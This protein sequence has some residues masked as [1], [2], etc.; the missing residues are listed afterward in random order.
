MKDA[1]ADRLGAARLLWRPGQGDCGCGPFGNP[2]TEF[3]LSEVE[4]LRGTL[5]ASMELIGLPPKGE[6]RK[7][8]EKHHGMWHRWEG[9]VVS[10]G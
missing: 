9:Q 2:S 5:R 7:I 1:A 6:R 10:M 8:L 3:T 4:V